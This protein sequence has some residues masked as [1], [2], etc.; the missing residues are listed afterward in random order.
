M[1]QYIGINS[2]SYII[3]KIK[4]IFAPV[5]HLHDS[6]D[7][8]NLDDAIT[9]VLGNYG[10]IPDGYTRCSYIESRMYEL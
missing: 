3:N 10:E 8:Q 4:E 7:I 6:S 9:D 5:N 1:K 2:F